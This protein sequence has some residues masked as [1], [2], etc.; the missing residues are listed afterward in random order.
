MRNILVPQTGQMP[1]VAGR[2]FF[3]VICSAS[4]ISWEARHFTQYPCICFPYLRM[5]MF[6][7]IPTL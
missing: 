3:I 4:L 1:R 6:Q 7:A 2:P 5:R